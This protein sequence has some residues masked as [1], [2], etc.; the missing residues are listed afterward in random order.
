MCNVCWSCLDSI[1]S[2][3]FLPTR[4]TSTLFITRFC[5]VLL[6]VCLLGRSKLNYFLHLCHV[7][8]QKRNGPD[9]KALQYPVVFQHKQNKEGK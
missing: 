7:K 2:P 4:P 3:R 6:F 1:L 9:L 8:K 5:S